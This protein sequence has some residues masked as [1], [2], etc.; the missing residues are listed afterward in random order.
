MVSGH[1]KVKGLPTECS[2]GLY[3][4]IYTGIIPSCTTGTYSEIMGNLIENVLRDVVLESVPGNGHVCAQSV[5]MICILCMYREACIYSKD[6]LQAIL[7]VC[8]IG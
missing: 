5:Q 7:Y 6:S 3:I 8:S 2:I 1:L 4:Y